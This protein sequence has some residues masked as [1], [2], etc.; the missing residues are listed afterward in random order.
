S[1]EAPPN[2]PPESLALGLAGGDQRR[3]RVV[4]L[5]GEGVERAAVAALD[6]PRRHRPEPGAPAPAVRGIGAHG[7]REVFAHRLRVLE[8]AEGEQPLVLGLAVAL[9][10]VVEEDDVEA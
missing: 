9:D 8:S 6:P 3:R 5:A 2:A 7:G 10:E 1:P 4:S